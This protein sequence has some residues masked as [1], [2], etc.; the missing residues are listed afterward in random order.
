MPAP[1]A[2]A[3]E[4]ASWTGEAAPANAD[5]L[6][7][8]ASE[9]IDSILTAPFEVDEATELPTDTDKAEALR[10]ATCAQVHFWGQTGAEHDIDGLAGSD[11]SVGALSGKRPPERSPQAMRILKTASLL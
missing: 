3:T 6:L 9:L 5:W 1:Y 4:L 11:F 10:D 2:T 7:A 8:R